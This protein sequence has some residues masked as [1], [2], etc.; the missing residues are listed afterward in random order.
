QLRLIHLEIM[1]AEK[2]KL[3][4]NDR[5]ASGQQFLGTEAEFTE[6][7]SQDPHLWSN[8]KRE[9]WKDEL[10]SF[11]F[12]KTSTCNQPEGEVSRHAEK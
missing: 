11:V 6:S 2:D 4:N 10:D 9:F 3:A 7:A 12:K 1:T 8:D 5:S